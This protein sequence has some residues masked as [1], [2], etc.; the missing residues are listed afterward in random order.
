[1][2]FINQYELVALIRPQKMDKLVSI[3][4]ILVEKITSNEGII[5][6]LESWG[7]RTLAF[8]INNCVRAEYIF[9]KFTGPSKAIEPIR[10]TLNRDE[11]VILHSIMK[12][13]SEFD[14]QALVDKTST[15]LLNKNLKITYNHA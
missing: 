12:S 14:H 15:E 4:D 3:C 7:K 13:H 11:S 8:Q 5:L 9:V 6:A 1:M 10:I 2:I